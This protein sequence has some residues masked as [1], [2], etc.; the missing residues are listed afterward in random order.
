MSNK[1]ILSIDGGGIRGILPLVI[2]KALEERLQNHKHI[3]SYVDLYAGTSTGA[4]IVAALHVGNN[5]VPMLAKDILDIY[6]K[7]G[8]QMFIPSSDGKSIYR[9]L[10]MRRLINQNFG[11]LTLGEL[12]NNYVFPMLNIVDQS[13]FIY[14]SY[15]QDSQY[16]DQ[17]LSEML[18]ACTAVPTYFEP[19][20]LFGEMLADGVV[21]VK[22][23][24][25]I[26]TQ[27]FLANGGDLNELTVLSLGTGHLAG[28]D[29][30]IE[31]KALEDHFN[32][33]KL[34]QS[35]RNQ[36]YRLQP[37]LHKSSQEMDNASPENIQN[38]ITDAHIW[39]SQN[40]LILDQIAE[41][42]DMK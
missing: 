3:A 11:A 29:D 18:M 32:L 1:I 13:P 24:S 10:P 9:S 38:L 40:E 27:L 14:S 15:S 16:K 26:S 23:P 42:L 36:Y 33:E 6:Q 31:T 21:Y 7:R 8:S 25:L 35:N 19:I 30:E 34:F 20:F 2:L 22:N 41:K 12:P 4:L 28:C 37:E 17:A 39:V 5:G